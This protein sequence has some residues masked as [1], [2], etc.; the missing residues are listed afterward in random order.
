MTQNVN[1]DRIAI[2]LNKPRYPENIGAVARAMRN[3]GL[4]P[5]VDCRSGEFRS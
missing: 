4:E 5:V 1:F 2:V 3:M